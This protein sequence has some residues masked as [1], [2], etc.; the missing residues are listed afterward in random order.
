[1]LFLFSEK[2]SRMQLRFYFLYNKKIFRN[3]SR[4]H[5]E[6][7]RQINLFLSKHLLPCVSQH[8]RLKWPSKFIWSYVNFSISEYKRLQHSNENWII[9]FW[10]FQHKMHWKFGHFDASNINFTTK[11]LSLK[12]KTK[13]REGGVSGLSCL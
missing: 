12:A 3:L 9:G 13:E 11:W 10:W 4:G 5:F 8:P 7:S 2:C 6:F 1:M